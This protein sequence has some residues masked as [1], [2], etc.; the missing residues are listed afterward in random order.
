MEEYVTTSTKPKQFL[1][2]RAKE[3]M[4]QLFKELKIS[5][6]AILPGV[7]SEAIDARRKGEDWVHFREDNMIQATEQVLEESMSEEKSEAMKSFI[8]NVINTD[9][10]RELNRALSISDGKHTKFL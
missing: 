2:G 8:Q 3:I 9:A 6:L 10:A 5:E 7:I 4:E 1:A